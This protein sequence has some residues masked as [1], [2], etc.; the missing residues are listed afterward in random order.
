M[1]DIEWIRKALE[2]LENK[3]DGW[4]PLCEGRRGYLHERINS[5]YKWMLVVGGTILAGLAVN[6]IVLWGKR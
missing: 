3:I 5:L 6:F 2:R 4:E 1:T